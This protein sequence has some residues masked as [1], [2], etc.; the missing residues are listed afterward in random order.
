MRYLMLAVTSATVLAA[1]ALGR[2]GPDALGEA[3]WLASTLGWLLAI[4]AALAT[5]AAPRPTGDGR[6]EGGRPA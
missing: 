2:Y 5:V 1:V 3:S 4:G 6:E